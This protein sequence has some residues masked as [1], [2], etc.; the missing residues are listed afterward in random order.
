MAALEKS[1]KIEKVHLI[2][3]THLDVGF[4]D[5]AREVV[6]L[7]FTNFIP[8]AIETARQLRERGGQER[9]IWTTGSWL[10]D[11]F[12]EKGSAKD[13][14]LLEAAI[15]AGDIVWHGLPFTTHSELMDA[16]LF[17]FGLSMSQA[18]DR[19]FG[20]KTIAAKMT[21]VPGHTRGI[22]PL[23]SEAGIKFLHIGVN[24]ASTPPDVPPVFVWYDE[25]SGRDVI[26]MYQKGSYGDVTV[27][28]G[29]R[30]AI[31]FAHTN[32]NAGPPTAEQALHNFEEVRQRFPGAKVEAST[33]DAFASVLQMIISKL[34]V[35]T[36]ELGDTW[37][38]GVGSDPLKVSQYRALMRFH[39]EQRKKT[40][41]AVDKGFDEFSRR[42]I[43]IPE[44]TWGMDL[45]MHL[46]DFETYKPSDFRGARSRPNFK[47]Y[48]A[49][50]AEQ[51]A[52]VDE[53][54]Q[55]LGKSDHADTAKL[56]LAEC[57]PARPDTSNFN[58]ITDLSIL[59][60]ETAHCEVGFNP[61]TGAINHLN[62]WD[63]SRVWAS[64]ENELCA[65]R[66]EVFSQSD[67]DRFYRQYNINKRQVAHWALPDF[68]KPG[69][70]TQ[71]HR[72]WS[73]RVTQAYRSGDKHGDYIIL[74]LT[75]PEE[76]QSEYGCPRELTLQYTFPV[77]EPTIHVTFQWFDKPASRL[78]E[79]MWLSFVPKISDPN[80]WR[81]HKIDSWISPL[82]VIRDGN[83]HLHAVNSGITHA[84]SQGGLFIQTLDAP[85]V[86]PGEPSL[87]D[88]NN[89]RPV[90]RGGMHFNL[91]NNVWGTN[92]PTWYEDD[93]RFRFILRFD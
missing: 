86:A 43:M 20:K 78:P 71:E 59:D 36:Q 63:T 40:T 47:K 89:R 85:L 37:I 30:E 69:L 15:T 1:E 77:A 38:H 67:Y 29:L 12:L 41:G 46:E 45:K 44:H 70:P 84:G 79:A 65:F 75:A 52:Y 32:D 68:T 72:S 2:F 82:D 31:A 91:Y 55:A 13:K 64:S 54:I 58:Q 22:V 11:E 92:F 19:R 35:I 48:E 66:Y 53:A 27:V 18:L 8:T 50:W 28:P 7:Y 34:P 49:S 42:L 80:G 87:L 23:L 21:D 60:F 51:R 6:K 5:Y 62:H 14:K 9:F 16:E 76:S 88:F 90:L 81:L 24:G 73:A 56:K 74:N 3:K 17:R 4:T 39:A 61:A 57:I 93:A 33:L 83:R 10:I 26:V 25:A